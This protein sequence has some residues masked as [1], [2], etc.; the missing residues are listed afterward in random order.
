MK[1][2]FISHLS[3]DEICNRIRIGANPAQKGWR[4]TSDTF[5]YE[6]FDEYH[7]MLIHTG[8]MGASGHA[9]F[10]TL[11]MDGNDTIITGR[12][13]VPR[14]IRQMFL[15]F[16]FMLLIFLLLQGDFIMMLVVLPVFALWIGV[17]EGSM[18]ML[19][20]LLFKTD[21]NKAINFIKERLLE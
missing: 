2:K 7:F 19:A 9:F 5:F 17:L 18:G 15:S 12:F 8:F 6:I 21:G 4:G 20:Q 3:R 14:A 11:T 13:R 1:Y 16:Y 10:G